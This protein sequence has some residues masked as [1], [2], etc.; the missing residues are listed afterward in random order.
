MAVKKG[1][2][3]ITPQEL[4]K[5]LREAIGDYEKV[6][7]VDLN[8]A[9]IVAARSA[10]DQLRQKSPKK[11][12]AYAKS[13]S[14]KNERNGVTGMVTATVYAKAPHYRLTHLLENGHAKVNGGRVDG[15]PHIRP[16]EQNAVNEF[17]RLTKE[18]IERG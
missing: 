17:V 9:A 11:T 3:E 16:A 1:K 2:I 4:D 7:E 15:I 8:N 14:V 10:R 6:L 5:A 12:G 13:W 18:A